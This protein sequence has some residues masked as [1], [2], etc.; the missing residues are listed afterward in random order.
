MKTIAPSILSAN[1]LKLEQEILSL[2]PAQDIW[3]HLDVMD[4]K[5]VPNSTFSF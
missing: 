1:F 2:N 4:G 3:I 5:F